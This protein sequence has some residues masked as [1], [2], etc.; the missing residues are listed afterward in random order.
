[1]GNTTKTLSP[2]KD[3][4]SKTLPKEIIEKNSAEEIKQPESIIAKK[5]ASALV[6]W[7]EGIDLKLTRFISLS[8]IE[9][10]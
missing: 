6:K 3:E 7:V 4:D 5:P 9:P 8:I 1:M 10:L 2:K